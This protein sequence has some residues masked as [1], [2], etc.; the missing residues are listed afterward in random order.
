[1]GRDFSCVYPNLKALMVERDLGISDLGDLLESGYDSAYSR[2][3]GR[4]KF[5]KYDQ[6][7]LCDFFGTA[8]SDWLFYRER[9]P[10]IQQSFQKSIPSKSNTIPSP[11]GKQ[12]TSQNTLVNLKFDQKKKARSYAVYLDEEVVLALDQLA[13]QHETSRSNVLNTILKNVLFT[14][15]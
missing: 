6:T 2:L 15:Q 13:T 7:I 1:M 3:I 8:D 12:S 10:K 9:N 11:V 14:E 4:S 5:S